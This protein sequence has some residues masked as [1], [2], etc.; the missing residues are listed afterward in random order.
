MRLITLITD[1]GRQG[2]LYAPHA[3]LTHTGRQEG[4]MRLISYKPGRKEGSMRLIPL[5]S[6]LRVL[7]GLFLPPFLA[8]RC[9][10]TC[11]HSR[12]AYREA[13]RHVQQGGYLPTRV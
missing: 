13:G 1:T 11:T 3:T 4:S 5:S 6:S 7:R 8:K 12:E 2:G 9:I 10:R